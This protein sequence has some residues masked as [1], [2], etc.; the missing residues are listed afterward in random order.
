MSTAK[1]TRINEFTKGLQQ[2]C[3]GRWGAVN[4]KNIS[5]TN[6]VEIYKIE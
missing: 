4:K 6:A 2:M 1:V 3:C 5:T